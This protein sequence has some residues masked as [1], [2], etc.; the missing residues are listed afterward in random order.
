MINKIIE[1]LFKKNGIEDIKVSKSN[2]PDLCDYQSN[3][4]FKIAKKEG[5]S[6]IE[7]GKEVEL[8][9]NDIK[10]FNDYFE[11]VQFVAPGFLNIK[12]N[13]NFIC[14]VLRKMS[15]DNKFNIQ[16]PEKSETFVVDYCGA[17]VAKPLHVGHMRTTIVGESIARIIRFMGHKTICDVHLG[18]Y[19]LQIGEVIYA[20]L[21]D[22]IPLEDI[23]I[24][25]LDVAYPKMSARCKEDEKL[26][27]ECARITKE[28]QDGN[29]EYRKLWKKI[30]DVSVEDIKKNCNYLG[31]KFDYWYGESDAYPYIPKIEKILN[32]KGLLRQSEGALVVDVEEPT[33]KKE[34]PPLLFK[35]SN[36]AYLYASTDLACLL[37]RKEDFNP[38]HVLYVTD[39]RQALHFEQVFRTIEKCGIFKRTQ[40]EHLGYGTVNGLDGKPFKTREGTAPKLESLYNDIKE[41]FISKKEENKNLS[42][43]D[44]D[45]IVN[46][47]LK[48]GDLQNS[49]EKDYIFNIEKFS[50]T[51][52]KTGPYILYTY[53]RVNKILKDNCYTQKDLSSK[54]Y[55]ESDRNL[56]M[57]LFDVED[58]IYLAYNNRNP[59]YLADYVYDLCLLVN[60]FYQNNNIS[61]LTDEENKNDWLYVLNL[62]NRIIKEVLDLLVIQIPSK[63]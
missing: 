14:N 52:G 36:G 34:I 40:L 24:N 59:F 17:N 31:A 35:K 50:D 28:L 8:K 54:I 16:L 37:Q 13:N 63:M 19:G 41:I 9:I 55:N 27:E 48:Y 25:Y 2:R 32:E 4:I 39:L 21:E 38:D 49:K 42:N 61:N 51:I 6:P 29:E 5:K 1:E 43:E 46:S 3:D 15:N 22:K 10:N 26:K 45:K 53:L 20:I 33:D 47:I 62:S 58:Y 18:D 44:L 23:D 12:I 30:L 57:K 60:N 7:V 11:S 56:R